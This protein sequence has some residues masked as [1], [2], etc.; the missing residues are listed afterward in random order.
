MRIFFF[1]VIASIVFALYAFFSA[2]VRFPELE[3]AGVQITVPQIE[4]EPVVRPAVPDG[5]KG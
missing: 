2:P 1:V 3:N 5:A 4:Y